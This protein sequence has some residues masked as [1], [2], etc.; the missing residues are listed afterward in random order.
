MSLS[1]S[2]CLKCVEHY[3]RQR[4][5]LA[6]IVANTLGQCGS[7]TLQFLG[8]L[9]D[10]E[11]KNTFGFTL[12]SSETENLSQTSLPSESTQ[13]ENDYIHLHGLKYH[14]NRLQLLTCV[15][16]G[17][18]TRIIGQTFDLTCSPDYHRCLETAPHN[19]SP[20]VPTFDLA[21]QDSNLSQNQAQS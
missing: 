8:N 14:K 17:V 10:H 12:D 16:E 11:A 3:Q 20:I 15:F 19:W 6:P 2:Q 4:L 13:Q 21:S 9:A 1:N 7:D 5:T 18:T